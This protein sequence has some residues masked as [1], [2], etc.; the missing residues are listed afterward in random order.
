MFIQ[1]SPCVLT[2]VYFYTECHVGLANNSHNF[3]T[4]VLEYW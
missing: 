2:E 4:V 1:D 3:G